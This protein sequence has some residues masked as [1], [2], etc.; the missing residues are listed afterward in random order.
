MIKRKCLSETECERNFDGKCF[1]FGLDS[2]EHKQ[3]IRSMVDESDLND[4]D[5][6]KTIF[7]IKYKYRPVE[8]KPSS[9]LDKISCYLGNHKM[10]IRIPPRYSDLSPMSNYYQCER[11]HCQKF[12]IWTDKWGY[13]D[14]H[15][16]GEMNVRLLLDLSIKIRKDKE[17]ILK[18]TEIGEINSFDL[19]ESKDAIDKNIYLEYLALEELHEKYWQMKDELMIVD[20]N[21]INNDNKYNK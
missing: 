20:S 13:I 19:M 7:E 15:K 17:Q 4:Y 1:Q 18:N 21:V 14:F 11:E 9:F 6:I 5:M 3:T 12:R 10:Q 16:A 8:P 2:C